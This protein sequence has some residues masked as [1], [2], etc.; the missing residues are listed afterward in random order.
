MV[1]ID[2]IAVRSVLVTAGLTFVVLLF[3]KQVVEA[4]LDARAVSLQWHEVVSSGAAAVRL[5][6][7][8]FAFPIVTLSNAIVEVP[9][10]VPF[11]WFYDFPLAVQYI[12]PQRLTGLTHPPTVSMIN[13]IRFGFD[14]FGGVP[15][16]LVSLGYFSA[17]VLGVVIV[18]ASFGALLAMFEK[19]LPATQDALGAVLRVAWMLFLGM[20]VMYGDPQLIWSGGLHLLVLTGL[21]LWLRAFLAHPRV[22]TS[23]GVS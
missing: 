13:S 4:G 1:R 20:R 11:R 16:D 19:V 14:P 17:G 12:V 9:A 8:E 23:L 6:L 5:I 7:A 15:V 3:G 21:L 22:K 10:E 2:R 18:T